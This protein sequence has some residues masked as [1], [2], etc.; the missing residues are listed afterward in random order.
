[1]SYIITFKFKTN[2]T[3]TLISIYFIHLLHKT[4]YRKGLHNKQ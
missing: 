2:D 4:R 1:M 3:L